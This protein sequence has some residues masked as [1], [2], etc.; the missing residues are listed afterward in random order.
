MSTQT[1]TSRITHSRRSQG[2]RVI[3]YYKKGVTNLKLFEK[4]HE[5]YA[6]TIVDLMAYVDK[7]VDT[8]DAVVHDFKGEGHDDSG[9]RS[10]K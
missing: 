8:Q 9:G 3:A 1:A 2:R 4:I 6:H 5:D 7:L 10:R